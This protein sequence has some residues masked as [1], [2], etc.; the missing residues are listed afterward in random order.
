MELRINLNK[1]NKYIIEQRFLYFFWI[2][3]GDRFDT[4]Y[5]AQLKLK[6][7]ENKYKKR[8]QRECNAALHIT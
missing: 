6:K 5:Q 1:N 2:D 8:L 3:I 7:Y 4:L